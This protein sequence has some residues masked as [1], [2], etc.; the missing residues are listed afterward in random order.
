MKSFSN[1]ELAR[2]DGKNGAPAY[3][4]YKE[5]VYYVSTSFQWR[6]G[7]HQVIHNAREDLIDSLE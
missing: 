3:I 5:K 2:Y 1:E 6:S 4:A 7:R